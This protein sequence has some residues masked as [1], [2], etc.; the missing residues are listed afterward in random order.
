MDLHDLDIVL[1]T[2]SKLKQDIPT[3]SIFSPHYTVYR[4]DRNCNR[5]GVFQAIKSDIVSI[6][7][8]QLD[9]TCEIMCSSIRLS[10]CKTLYLLSFHRP[11]NSSTDVL[12]QLRDS[13]GRVFE[14][15]TNHPNI[16]IG[17]DVNF[18]DINW[19]QEVPTPTNENT[20]AQ[21]Y[22]FRQF[23]G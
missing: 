13:V 15:S 5:G 6:E 19:Q 3:Y 9:N 17:G 20:A 1:G 8:S 23:L 11:P 22:N 21:H 4:R 14:R 2:E 7:A 18:G 10:T 12:D 16:I